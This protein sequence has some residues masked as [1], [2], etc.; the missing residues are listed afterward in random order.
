MTVIRFPRQPRDETVNR[1]PIGSVRTVRGRMTAHADARLDRRKIRIAALGAQE[2]RR[3]RRVKLSLPGRYLDSEGGEYACKLVDISPGGGRIAT[4]HP[5]TPGER[6]VMI[7]AGLGRIEGEV[8]RA[9]KAGFAARFMATQRKRD[10]LADAITWRFN[11]ARLGLEED[12]GSARK[13]SS[14]RA[15]LKLKDGVVIRADV[16]DVSMTGAAFA[17]L[18][19]PRV[20]ET[21]KVGDMK[22]RVARWLENGIAVAFDPPEPPQAEPSAD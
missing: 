13:P 20:G 5:P 4:E 16:L 19:R 7:L 11:M 8:I 18:E 6:V 3:H 10:K 12:R 22:G 9:G 1:A 2:K 21:V 14:G 15:T 17:C